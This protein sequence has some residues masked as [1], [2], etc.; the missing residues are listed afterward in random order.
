MY[1]CT[2]MY[3]C[4]KEAG[5]CIIMYEHCRMTCSGTTLTS[6]CS[7]TVIPATGGGG[8]EGIKGL[9]IELERMEDFF[10]MIELA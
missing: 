7:L 9:G 6:R 3:R 8:G 5:L 4:G 2:Y 1:A 10:H